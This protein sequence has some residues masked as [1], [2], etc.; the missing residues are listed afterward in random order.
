MLLFVRIPA[1]GHLYRGPPKPHTGSSRLAS[2]VS[3]IAHNRP[4]LAAVV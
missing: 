1:T 4:H 2:P 3:A